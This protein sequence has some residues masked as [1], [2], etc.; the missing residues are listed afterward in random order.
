MST[1][2]FVKSS[3]E[4]EEATF[5]SSLIQKGVMFDLENILK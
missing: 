5:G 1:Q 4:I 3:S 2:L